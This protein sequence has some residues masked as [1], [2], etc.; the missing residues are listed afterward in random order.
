MARDMELTDMLIETFIG[1]EKEERGLPASVDRSEI[2]KVRCAF[3]SVEHSYPEKQQ[4]NVIR[5][6]CKTFVDSEI[7]NI[8]TPIALM[9]SKYEFSTV[10]F[11]E[12]PISDSRRR[13]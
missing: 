8:T 3:E 1:H 2:A 13:K 7:K 4:L 11:A 6:C 5:L 10:P 12:M 9:I